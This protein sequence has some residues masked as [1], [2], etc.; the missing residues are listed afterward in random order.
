MVTC[1]AFIKSGY[2]ISKCSHCR[3]RG[4]ATIP[5]AMR[6]ASRTLDEGY[7]AG[8]PHGVLKE[9]AAVLGRIAGVLES[10]LAEL[11]RLAELA[12]AA[13]GE[14]RDGLVREHATV[15]AMALR[16]RWYLVVQREANG[17]YD[18]AEVERLYPI[19]S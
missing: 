14:E 6:T 7:G 13:A 9:R 16:Y 4:A 3:M 15:R 10:L 11:D 12:A 17:L 5:P 1:I 2:N 18:E 8:V 19:P